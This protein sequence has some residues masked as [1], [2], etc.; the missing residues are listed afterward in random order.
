M[1]INNSI[2]INL[3]CMIKVRVRWCNC[4]QWIT[5]IGMLVV[6]LCSPFSFLLYTRNDL[7][8]PVMGTIFLVARV[9]AVCGI[10]S[11][12]N[13]IEIVRGE[14]KYYLLLYECY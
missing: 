10:N 1:Y 12:S 14:A 4:S 6:L 13:A 3:L 2:H 5:L 7:A 8:R 11:R 9:A